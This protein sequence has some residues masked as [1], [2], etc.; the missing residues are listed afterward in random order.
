MDQR[1]KALQAV[2][3]GFYEGRCEPVASSADTLLDQRGCFG[4][5]RGLLKK[6]LL[7]GGVDLAGLSNSSCT[8][9][10]WGSFSHD[11]TSLK[12]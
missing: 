8:K 12:E 5:S 6:L 4:R 9:K 7:S 10:P 3:E 2:A 11:E 1:D